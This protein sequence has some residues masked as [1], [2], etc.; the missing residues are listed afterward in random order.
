MR[1]RLVAD[2]PLIPFSLA[3][4][5]AAWICITVVHFLPRNAPGWTHF[6]TGALLTYGVL[7]SIEV[8]NRRFRRVQR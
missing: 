8:V 4:M 5:I 7:A 3:L 6:L 1:G 2:H